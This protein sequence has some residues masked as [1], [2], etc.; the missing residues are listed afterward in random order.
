MSPGKQDTDGRQSGR[1][2]KK[3]KGTVKIESDKGWLGSKTVLI[4]QE[5]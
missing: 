2:K 1:R 3:K 4:E 5:N